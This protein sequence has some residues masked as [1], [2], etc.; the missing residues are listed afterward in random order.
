MNKNQQALIAKQANDQ[1]ALIAKQ[2]L[3]FYRAINPNDEDIATLSGDLITDI[4]HL[5]D[6]EEID[7][8]NIMERSDF[9]YN[10]ETEDEQTNLK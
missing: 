3:L 1:R 2:V 7:F 6:K 9:H 5:C 8:S 4:R 10:A